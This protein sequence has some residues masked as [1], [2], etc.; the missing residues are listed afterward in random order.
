MVFDAAS[1]DRWNW[2]RNSNRIENSAFIELQRVD[3]FDIESMQTEV[4]KKKSQEQKQIMW[5]KIL[6]F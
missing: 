3:V 2:S 4:T 6:F 1:N 5:Q